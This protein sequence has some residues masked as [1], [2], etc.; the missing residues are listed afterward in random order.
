MAL[1]FEETMRRRASQS[2]NA[3][4]MRAGGFADITQLES[5]CA[6]GST[7]PAP[8][9]TTVRDLARFFV[10]QVPAGYVDSVL[11]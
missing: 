6:P 7:R 8:S 2:I 1:E 3:S 10:V 9:I 5:W 11:M 4:T